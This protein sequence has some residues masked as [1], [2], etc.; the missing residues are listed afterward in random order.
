MKYIVGK[1]TSGNYNVII[2]VQNDGTIA[3]LIVP[4]KMSRESVSE[5]SY[6]MRI[7]GKGKVLVPG[8]ELIEVDCSRSLV[9]AFKLDNDNK[10]TSS[11]IIDGGS[12]PV[13]VSR[14]QIVKWQSNEHG[15][16]K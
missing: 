4:L 15:I 7:S 16:K 1:L 9:M 10:Q 6:I 2:Q 8:G 3:K 13:A 14:D 11:N 12:C 5:Y